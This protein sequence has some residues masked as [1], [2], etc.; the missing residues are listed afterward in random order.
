M[1]GKM[2]RIQNY[3]S[4]LQGVLERL[5]LPDVRRSI[6]V[7]MEA[8]YAEKQIFVI[9]NGGSASTASHLACDLGKGTSMPGKPRFRVI[10]LTDNVATMSAWS[11]DVS[12]EHVFVEQLKNLVN[13]EDVVIGISAS[14]NSE[15]VI[16]AMRHAKE[17][18]CKTIGWSGFGGGTLATICDVN[19]IVD[20]NYYGPV[21][22]V[23]LILNHVLHA[24]IREELAST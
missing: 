7:I 5:A 15:N 20:S 9:G 19:V 23:H 24:W 3:I 8:Y 21:E 10:S 6:D 13:S 11:N 16:R 12:Y 2:D 4:H 22:D 18:G 14:G 17:I 1:L